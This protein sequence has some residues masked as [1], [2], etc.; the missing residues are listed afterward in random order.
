MGGFWESKDFSFLGQISEFPEKNKTITI[1]AIQEG[2]PLI[3]GRV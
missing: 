1:T 2:Q 3:P